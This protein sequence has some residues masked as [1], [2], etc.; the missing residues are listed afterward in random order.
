[1]DCSSLSVLYA[2][3]RLIGKVN[4]VPPR[5]FGR[6]HLLPEASH[7]GVPFVGGLVFPHFLSQPLAGYYA[8]EL[9]SCRWTFHLPVLSENHH[10]STSWGWDVQHHSSFP[11][12]EGFSKNIAQDCKPKNKPLKLNM[13]LCRKG[14]LSLNFFVPGEVVLFRWTLI[15]SP[16]IPIP[17]IWRPNP[18]RFPHCTG[19]AYHP[20]GGCQQ[21]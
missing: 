18:K 21:S 7:T 20:C 11:Q 2:W 4:V 19:A 1:M 3:L 16:Q 6:S 9:K 12:D 15:R 13:K 14:T 5:L 17:N 8:E 10:V